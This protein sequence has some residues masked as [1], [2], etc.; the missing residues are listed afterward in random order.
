VKRQGQ[1]PNAFGT[2]VKIL[3]AFFLFLISYSVF[4]QQSSVAA[5]VT[6]VDTSRI[7]TNY[8]KDYSD[9]LVLGLWQAEGTY[10]ITLAEKKFPKAADSSTVNYIAN[11]NHVSGVSL[12]Y[13]I[14]GFAFGY[15]SVPSGNART[16]NTDY[17][18]LGL[19]FTTRGF[20]FENSWRRYTGFYDNNTKNYTHPFNDSV[21]Y[22][23]FPHMNLRVIKSKL[24]YSF[25]KK[26]FALGAAYANVKRQV[27][28]RG[29][30]LLIGNFY[31]MN[32]YSDSSI[33]PFP[34]RG[35]YGTHWD[36]FNRMNIYAFSAGFGGTR[37]FVFW[38]KF[39][40]N[41]F[42]SLGLESQYRHYYTLPENDH[43]K[44]WRTW[45]AGDWRSSLGYNSKRFFIRSSSIFDLTNYESSDLMFKMNFKAVS[46]DFGYRFNFKAPKP[47]HKFQETKFY[48]MF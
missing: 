9:K 22:T 13:D 42:A 21:P 40:F 20:R 3:L 35:F 44:Y 10:D 46:F 48:K 39:F 5:S 16:G 18:D 37:T 29:S 30:W 47:Y 25:N 26:R 32:L 24:I 38:K 19:N 4:G 12:D 27:K 14:I 41:I 11:S 45:F 7:D 28:T 17:L 31:S 8:V 6:S 2:K 15:R 36:G 34:L 33:I 1:I 43:I 23:Q